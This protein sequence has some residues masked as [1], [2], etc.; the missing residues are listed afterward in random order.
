MRHRLNPERYLR[1]ECF[2]QNY[3]VVRKFAINIEN[4]T[5]I[6]I[7]EDGTMLCH[8]IDIQAFYKGARGDYI[9][10]VQVTIPPIILG[11]S[12][13]TFADKIDYGTTA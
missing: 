10:P 6:S 7:S 3:G 5:I 9:E 2:N 11:V 12:E 8:K 13:A 1:K 4:S